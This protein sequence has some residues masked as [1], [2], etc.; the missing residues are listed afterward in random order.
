MILFRPKNCL[1]IVDL[2]LADGLIISFSQ[3]GAT[4]LCRSPRV[5]DIQPL[6]GKGFTKSLCLKPSPSGEIEGGC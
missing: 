5:I 6:Q 3:P 2:Q 1:L 4:L